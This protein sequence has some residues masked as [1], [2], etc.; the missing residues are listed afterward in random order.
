MQS[1]PSQDVAAA[2]E[3]DYDEVAYN[4]TDIKL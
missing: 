2:K 3:N 1:G 4:M